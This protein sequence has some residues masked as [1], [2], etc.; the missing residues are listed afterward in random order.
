MRD[1]KNSL[2]EIGAEACDDVAQMKNLSGG[3]AVVETLNDYLIGALSH[4]SDDPV[5]RLLCG[6]GVRHT[7]S[8]RDLNPVSYGPKHPFLSFQ[9]KEK[10]L[11]YW[12]ESN[13]TSDEI[14][15]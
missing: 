10:V 11:R 9:V 7:G 13:R 2:R 15:R 1:V 12:I 14:V 4:L 5:S 3:G 6:G 8:E